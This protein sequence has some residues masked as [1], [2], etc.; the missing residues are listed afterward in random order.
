M[1][2]A[3]RLLTAAL[4]AL[5]ATLA[6]QEAPI[7]AP[8]AEKVAW[9]FN[10]SVFGYFPPEDT[11]YG[12]PT[13]MADRGALHLETRYNYEGIDTGSAW[14]GW[15]VGVG[16]ALRL[17]ATLM[18]GGVFGKTKGV[19]PGYEL[20]RLLGLLRALQRGRVRLRRR[21]LGQ[22]LLLQ[23]GPARVFPPRL[24]FGG[25]RFAADADLPD[26]P[27]RAARIPRRLQAREPEPER[28]RVQPRLGDAH[29]RHLDRRQLLTAKPAAGATTAPPPARG[30]GAPRASPSAS[31]G[32][33]RPSCDRR[34]REGGRSGPSSPS[35]GWPRGRP[36]CRHGSTRRR[37]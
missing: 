23:L 20:T 15:N 10:A 33:P 27:R 1:K 17:D 3:L 18:A 31:P 34:D 4:L 26:G 29:R 36:R 11:D 6:A 32:R 8:P 22:Q 16:D 28:L 35:G 19:A 21:G 25:S 14:V 5:P 24:A 30:R 9:E 2:I 12:Q 37:G 13:V 7:A